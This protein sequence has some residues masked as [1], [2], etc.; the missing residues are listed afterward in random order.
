MY[1]VR[2]ATLTYIYDFY[3]IFIVVFGTFFVLN[4]MIAVQTSY[5]NSTIEEQHKKL[6]ERKEQEQNT[7]KSNKGNLSREQIYKS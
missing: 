5:L 1:F 2:K 6:K 3:F 7:P 4:L